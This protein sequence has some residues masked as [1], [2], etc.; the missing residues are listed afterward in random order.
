M[1]ALAQQRG[2]RVE[3]VGGGEP[4]GGRQNGRL[5]ARGSQQADER[6]AEVAEWLAG[7]GRQDALAQR[8]YGPGHKSA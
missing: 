8:L 1:R 5:V 6:A 7:V 3:G 4:R 2:Q